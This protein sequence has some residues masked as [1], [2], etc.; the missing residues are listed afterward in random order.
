MIIKAKG[1]KANTS[2]RAGLL[3]DKM[4]KYLES[5]KGRADENSWSF[6]HN[7]TAFDVKGIAK[8]FKDNETLR[9]K[10]KKSIALHHV[11]LSF[12]PLDAHKITPAILKDLTEKYIELRGLKG[13]A[14]ARVHDAEQHPH[15]H[16]LISGNE[17]GSSKATSIRPEERDWI[18]EELEKYQLEKYPEL[19]HSLVKIREKNR[20][21]EK[22]KPLTEAEKKLKERL[23]RKP[24]NKELLKARLTAWLQQAPSVSAYYDTL[25]AHGFELY[26]Y[27]GKVRGIISPDGV[28]FRFATLGITKDMIRELMSER[29]KRLATLQ[30]GRGRSIDHRDRDR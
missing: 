26:E 6:F 27:R 19:S 24:T 23:G 20:D 14:F 17:L 21:L 18:H 15:V 29:E 22:E 5:D 13:I 1:H 28:K 12:H 30:E 25:Q 3:I 9:K 4:V 7:L 10:H 16:I 2:K 11:I 8:E